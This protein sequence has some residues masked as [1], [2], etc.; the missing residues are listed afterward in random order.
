MLA[1]AENV[2]TLV[3]LTPRAFIL[4]TNY[5]M[6][7]PFTLMSLLLS[8]VVIAQTSNV[9]YHES[10]VF[11][12][13][14][15][16]VYMGGIETEVALNIKAAHSKHGHLIDSRKASVD[17][18][19]YAN[20]GA[21]STSS[22]NKKKKGFNPEVEAS[23]A[24]NF[25]SGTPADNNI[26]ISNDGIVLSAVN[27]N[28]RMYDSDGTLLAFKTLAGI[29]KD[30]GNLNS[31]YDPHVVYDP[32]EDRFILIFLSGYSSKNTN[33]MIGFSQTNDPTG[34]WNFYRIPGNVHEDNTWSDYPFIG[35]TH[36]EVFIPVL[37]WLDGESGWDSE[38]QELIW[39]IDKQKG[40]DGEK[41]EYKYYDK[42]K[43][44]NRLVWNT[45]PVWGSTGP[46]GPNMYFVAN[47]AIDIENDSI[48]FFEITNTLASGKAELKTKIAIADVPYGIPPS[49]EQPRAGDSL[50]TNYADIH[51]AFYHY[52][53]IHFVGNS[54]S[55]E[56]KRA[57]IYYGV[58][59][60][61]EADEP[62]V[63]AQIFSVDSL[64]LNYPNI[65]YAGGG[66]IDRSCMIGLLH[67]SSTTNPGTSAL[68]VDRNGDFSDLIR[69]K[70][71]HSHINVMSNDQ[72][73]WGDYTGIQRQYNEP[74][75]CWI[76]GSF[77]N[78]NNS[79]DSWIASVKNTDPQLGASPINP[80]KFPSGLFPNP[81]SEDITLL[82]QVEAD[83]E[84]RI[85]MFS[86]NG[87]LVQDFEKEKLMVGEYKLNF[88]IG[89]LESGSYYVQVIGDSGSQQ[90]PFVKR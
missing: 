79:M 63:K 29:A 37:L 89:N 71:G 51:G 72:E 2:L 46:Y 25:T 31:A 38:A 81:A 41:L 78:P 77:G 50:R 53:K 80:I 34:D 45:R 3:D 86:S 32:E 73:R 75:T 43:V 28:V 7:V 1:L 48:F 4:H 21:A 60:N 58:M 47:R 16:V 36:D 27:S 67:S 30:L 17:A 14:P 9:S 13:T 65:A 87:S 70:E 55:P 64:D 54:I 22:A 8:V 10:P 33:L 61:L 52:G 39:Q 6:R 56:T 12:G 59:E 26:A 88:T 42:I 40:Y 11:T 84:Y 19:A 82:L 85:L 62:S 24:A 35:I 74:G 76:L 18:M 5:Y 23:Y 90:F 20:R 68:F 49:A 83:D 57:G 69:I 15:Q 66:G 44:G